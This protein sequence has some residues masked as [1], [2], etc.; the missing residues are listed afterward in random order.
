MSEEEEIVEWLRKS[1]EQVGELEPV[2]QTSDGE[3]IDGR[4]RLRAY[5]GWKIEVLDVDDFEGVVQRIHRNIHR[6]VSE[7]ERKMQITQLA[8]IL[9]KRGVKAEDI[10]DE[11]KKVV[12][13]SE[14]YIRRLLP[15]KFKRKYKAKRLAVKSLIPK[16]TEKTAIS[17]QKAE[18]KYYYCPVCGA[19]LVLK[20][21]M[22]YQT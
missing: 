5:P 9:E 15:S 18:P 2:Y 11:I 1:R 21:D 6:K 20:G 10:I 22:L 7:S 17:K 8:L 13:F 19:K 3:I 12:P 16:A 4:H 14:D